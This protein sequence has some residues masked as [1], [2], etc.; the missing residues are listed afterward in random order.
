MKLDNVRMRDPFV[1]P[2]PAENTYYLYCAAAQEHIPVGF[3]VYTSRDLVDWTGPDPVFRASPEFWSD[4][5]FWAP[6]VHAYADAYYLFASF[7]AAGVCRG[8]QI[9]RS[10][11]PR[12]PFSPI[13]AGPVTPHE[14]E[15][16]DGTLYVDAQAPWIVFCHEWVQVKDGEM[17]AMPLSSDLTH[18]LTAPSL[19]FHASE[20]D[21]VTRGPWEGNWVTDGP[22]LYRS[23]AG[24]LLMIWSSFTEAGYAVGI[25][26]STTG[27]IAGPWQH[28]T[29]TLYNNDGGHGALFRTF[30][31]RLILSLHQP[32][33]GSKER[34][35][36]LPLR[37]EN[38]T[39]YLVDDRSD[40]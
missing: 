7:K 23:P 18:A 4:R 27:T 10:D 31:G 20:A 34:V 40:R 15:C 16:L 28:Q 39:L 30:D 17:C 29:E 37:E 6:E 13:S 19:L 12:G 9:M 21:W 3:D 14:W 35:H 38:D 8:T 2:V 1:L 32:N 11:S 5:D 33:A 36:F 24:S 25:A 22:C 26:R